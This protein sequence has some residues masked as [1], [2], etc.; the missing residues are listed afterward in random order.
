MKTTPL[1]ALAAG[2]SFAFFSA[3]AMAQSGSN[4]TARPAAAP[5]SAPAADSPQHNDGAPN[6]AEMS[7]EEE[8]FFR[9]AVQ[10]T[11]P[12]RFLRAGE[13]YFNADATWIIF[14][15]IER[16]QAVEGQPAP[17]PDSFYSMYVAKLDR[18]A[19]GTIRGLTHITRISP[20]GSA[21]TC[22][23]FSHDGRHVI[24]GSTIGAPSNESP[25]GFQVKSRQYVWQ[26]PKE[27]QIVQQEVFD[28]A[29]PDQVR[30]D[31]P[32]QPVFDR[33][34]YDAECS[35]T[36][37]GRF[38]LHTQVRDGSEPADGDLYI[39]DRQTN[40]Q[41]PVVTA[42]GYDGGPFYS[43]DQKWI[44]YRS[45]RKGDN[46]LQ[47][48]VAELITEKLADGGE[49]PIGIKKEYPLTSNPYVNWAPFWHPSQKFLVYSSSQAGGTGPQAHSNY[50]TYAIPLNLDLIRMG[51]DATSIEPIRITFAPGADLLPAFSDDGKLMIWTSQ[52]G[53]GTEGGGRP[54]SQ[55]WI[56]EWIGDSV[57]ESAGAK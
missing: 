10:L 13:S 1:V 44:C 37:D 48:Y 29:N 9:N 7:R 42:D 19:Q 15:G 18:D 16:P 2:A 40:T 41:I 33:N 25:S 20:P 28:P 23:W 49:G 53:G 12:D 51:K 43:P 27:M 46:L 45:D 21:N 50:E 17:Q 39:Y 36:R 32:L 14:Q 26:F 8:R 34:G 47:L 57:I 4:L 22:G 35:L 11:F 24:Y 31:A 52:R 38:V 54:S 30:A 6:A 56:A 3:A 5:A 55:L